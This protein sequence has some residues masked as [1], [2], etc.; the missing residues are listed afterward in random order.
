MEG[1]SRRCRPGCAS[2][3]QAVLAG[4]GEVRGGTGSDQIEKSNVKRKGEGRGKEENRIEW[5]RPSGIDK[6]D[7]QK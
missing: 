2:V 4:G 5:D 7:E 1:R 6:C 3:D